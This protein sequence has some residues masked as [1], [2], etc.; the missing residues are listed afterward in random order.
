VEVVPPDEVASADHP[1]SPPAPATRHEPEPPKPAPASKHPTPPQ[2]GREERAEQP[3]TA[4]V[5]PLDVEREFTLDRERIETVLREVRVG[6]ANFRQDREVRLQELQRL[7]IELAL[8][9]ATRVLH[10]RVEANEFPIDAKLRDMIAQLGED[11]PVSV[12][13]NPA[14]LELLKS[15]LGDQPLTADRDDPRFIADASLARGACQ[16][17]GRESML[18]SDVSRELQEIRDELLRSLG[19]ARS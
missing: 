10:E 13:L 17:E 12:R 19:N 15:R 2:P 6:V 18:V 4:Q 11:V 3:E 16:V 14:D 1:A 5:W 7:A 8:T 9:I